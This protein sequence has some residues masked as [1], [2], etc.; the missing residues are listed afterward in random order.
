MS[1][2]TTISRKKVDIVYIINSFSQVGD[3]YLKAYRG[4]MLAGNKL[5]VNPLTLNRVVLVMGCCTNIANNESHSSSLMVCC[6]HC[7]RQ[8]TVG[9][10]RKLPLGQLGLVLQA[11]FNLRME[12]QG[13]I[14]Q[15]RKNYVFIERFGKL[16]RFF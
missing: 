11:A 3:I 4:K 14:V 16:V 15:Y 7:Q 5:F 6:S 1:N 8:V 2:G 12:L 13:R 9:I 10:K